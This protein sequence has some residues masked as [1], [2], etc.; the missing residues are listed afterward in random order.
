M[1]RLIKETF[2]DFISVAD[3][4]AAGLVE[5]TCRYIEDI[6]LDMEK[7]RDQ[8]YDGA[9]VMSGVHNGV[10]KLIEDNRSSMPVPFIHCAAHNLNLVINDMP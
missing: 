2:L 1:L 7:L 4:T 9:S 3:E 10:Q 6:G 5:T 8:G